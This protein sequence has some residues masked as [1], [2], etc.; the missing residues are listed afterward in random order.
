MKYALLIYEDEALYG[1]DKSGPVT[2]LWRNNG[3]DQSTLL[4][5]PLA[6]YSFGELGHTFP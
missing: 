2:A 1:P 4:P 5:A 6:S 3:V